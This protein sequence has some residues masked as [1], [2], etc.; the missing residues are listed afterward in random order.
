MQGLGGG[1][2]GDLN[3]PPVNFSKFLVLLLLME[4][5]HGFQ[6]FVKQP[7]YMLVSRETL[8]P[9]GTPYNGLYGEAQPERVPFSGWR[10]IK[11]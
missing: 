7:K 11:G 4:R 1:G 9:G 10:Y 5:H 2:G 3:Q 8:P 6:D